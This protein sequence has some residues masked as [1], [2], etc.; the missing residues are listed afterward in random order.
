MNRT[1]RLNAILLHLQSK[2]VVTAQELA[3]RFNISVRTVYRDIRAIEEGGVP[4]LG[5]AGLGYSLD[6]NYHLPPVHLDSQEAL[7]L[8]I[9]GK[10]VGDLPDQET[11]NSYASALLKIRA[12]LPHPDKDKLE[13]WEN[14]IQVM[15]RSRAPDQQ[16]RSENISLIQQALLHARVVM[17]TY[18]SHYRQDSSLREVEPIGLLYYSH[19]WHLIAWCRWRKA[20]RDFRLDRIQAIEVLQQQ[21]N[22]HERHSIEEYLT[23][24]KQQ[25]PFQTLTVQFHRSALA[26]IA[27]YRYNMGFIAEQDI[28][29]NWQEMQFVMSDLEY[30]SR[31]LLMYTDSVRVVGPQTLVDKMQELFTEME[32]AAN[33]YSHIL[34]PS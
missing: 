21:F 8:M 34:S 24:L 12:I 28:D 6:K 25:Q 29:E 5:E 3:E 16:G 30:F 13:R 26:Y 7:A 19:Q 23:V 11:R 17:M 32:R 1:D 33:F 18:Y 14:T 10:L 31:W 20:Y 15:P 27:E 2:R 22:S 9:G 4:I